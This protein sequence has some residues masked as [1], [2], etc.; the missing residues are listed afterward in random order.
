MRIRIQNP[1]VIYADE[2]LI[3]VD[4]AEID[5]L[6]T[7]AAGN[8]RRRA[9]LCAHGSPDDL[10]HE[11]LIVHTAD[12]YVRPHKHLDKVESFHVVEGE[13]RIVLF[14][15]DGRID[16]VIRVGSYSTDRC[17]YYRLS[18]ASFH[19]VLIDSPVLVFHETT[20]GP[21]RPHETVWAPWAPDGSDA[22]ACAAYLG[23]IRQ[24]AGIGA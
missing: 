17:F 3:T 14:D 24:A 20:S 4:R 1:E 2:P 11:M 5:V 21:F 12:T 18:S 9:R 16:R 22:E 19:T 8:P 23:T 7:R 15:D 6:K 13:G 10:V